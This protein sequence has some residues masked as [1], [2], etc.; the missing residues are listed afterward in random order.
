MLHGDAAAK[1][2]DAIDR[3]IRDSLGVVE[4]PVQ[5]VQ[6]HVAIDLFEH[7]ERAGDRLVVGSVHSPRPFVLH[8]HAHDLFEFALHLRR[9]VG[10]RHAEILEVG[11][12]EHQHFTGAVVAEVIGALLVF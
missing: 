7:I 12:G 11:G 8:Q 10:A 5:A 4:E 6:R 2:G 9:H 1:C 3:S